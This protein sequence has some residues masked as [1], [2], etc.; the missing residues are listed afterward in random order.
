[1][2]PSPEYW[3][4]HE[5]LFNAYLLGR[6]SDKSVGMCML[7]GPGWRQIEQEMVA[8]M[9]AT[10]PELREHCLNT[11]MKRVRVKGT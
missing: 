1:M 2:G 6:Q 10:D 11:M 4:L 8:G 7:F 9:I 3:V 5:W